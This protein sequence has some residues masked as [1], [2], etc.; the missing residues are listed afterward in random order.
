MITFDSELCQNPC[1]VLQKEWLE[2]NGLGGYASSTILGTNTRRYHGLLV[3]ATRPPTGRVVLLSKVEE[4][5]SYKGKEYPLSTNIYP[6]AYHPQG[7]KYL[8]GFRLDPFPIF[9]Y[10]IEDLLIE[11]LVFMV[12]GDNTT[13]ILYR[14]IS[15][16]VGGARIRI[17]PMLAFRDHHSLTKESDNVNKE[18]PYK[19]GVMEFEPYPDLPKMYLYHNAEKRGEE[20]FWHKNLEYPEEASRGLPFQEDLFSPCELHFTFTRNSPCY[21][22]ASTSKNL[23]KA[24]ALMKRELIR[25]QDLKKRCR[26]GPLDE[27]SQGL[28]VASDSFVVSKSEGMKDIIAGY[29]WF[30]PWGRDTMIALPGLTLVTGRYQDARDILLSYA[31]YLNKGLLPNYFSEYDGTPFYT[32]ADASLWYIYATYKYLEYTDDLKTIR[33]YLFDS[34]KEIIEQYTKGTAN[35]IHVDID[36]LI[37]AG[38]PNPQLTWMDAQVGGKVVTP[39]YGKI[40]EINALW[41]NALRIMEALAKALGLKQEADSYLQQAN[42]VRESFNTLFWKVD[43]KYL[44]D[45]VTENFKEDAIRPNQVLAVSLPYSPLSRERQSAV[46]VKVWA[47]LLT[48]YGLKTLSP[49]EEGYKGHYTGGPASRDSTYHQ[50]TVWPWLMGPFITAYVRVY[51]EASPKGFFASWGY[52]SESQAELTE[53]LRYLLKHLAIHTKEAGLGFIS[54]IFDGNTPHAP[55]GCI[56]QAWSVAEVLRAYVEDILDIAPRKKRWLVPP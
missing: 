41:Y 51:G 45:Y 23:P 40:V 14:L 35:N 47:H 29:P 10:Q 8:S 19:E 33:R 6:G 43:E 48:P 5:L 2:T 25:R 52:K 31:R 26:W 44:Y 20:F 18:Y 39:R 34:L 42:K 9:I 28:V 11:K 36:G 38:G 27:F 16:G 22:V 37:V 53:E 30:G 3:A 54:E 4:W 12:Y 55:R 46:V 15:Q 21:L 49:R 32:S 13:A 24:E 50:G 1:L 7:Y 17:R 56:A